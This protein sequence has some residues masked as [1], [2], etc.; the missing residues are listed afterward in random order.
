VQII[1]PLNSSARR[2]RFGPLVV[3]YD[4]QV[5]SP[6]PWTFEQSQWAVELA[7]TAPPGPIVELCAGAGHIGLAA[8]VL[9]DRDLVQVEADPRAAHYAMQNA[10]RA[11]WAGRTEIRS[12]PLQVALPAGELFEL[13]IADPPYLRTA[14]ISRWPEDPTSAIDGGADGLEL[15]RACLT[16]AGEH[17][18]ATG[19]LLLQVAGPDQGAHVRSLLGT[20]P[21][22]RLRERAIRVID[23][24]RAV[25]LIGRT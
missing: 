6:R 16:V 5:L 2:C 17:L 11:G 13:M 1:S 19:Q 12:R 23:A 8:A 25:L 20:A 9:A 22:L 18:T 14:E 3:D 21:E 4:E 7:A 15:V 10:A 24:E